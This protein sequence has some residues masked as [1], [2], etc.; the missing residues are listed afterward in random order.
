MKK[1]LL[2][3]LALAVVLCLVFAAA[4]CDPPE[5]PEQP[6]APTEPAEPETPAK[7]S[8]PA[9]P[10]TPGEPEEPATPS[11]TAGMPLK[12]ALDILNGCETFVMESFDPY[13]GE[14]LTYLSYTPAPETSSPGTPDTYMQA[15][16]DGDSITALY[17][18]EST[19]DGWQ[20]TEYSTIGYNG[21]FGK[22]IYRS[23]EALETLL[24]NSLFDLSYWGPNLIVYCL[25][26]MYPEEEGFDI[27]A[28]YAYIEENYTVLKDGWYCEEGGNF[29][30]N[31]TDGAAQ[32]HADND[33]WYKWSVPT[34][35]DAPAEK[36]AAAEAEIAQHTILNAPIISSDMTLEEAV[37]RAAQITTYS[38]SAEVDGKTV[39]YGVVTCPE[40]KTLADIMSGA[41]A[42]KAVLVSY[43]NDKAKDI[44]YFKNDNGDYSVIFHNETGHPIGSYSGDEAAPYGECTLYA[45]SLP[46]LLA[47]TETIPQTQE[48]WDA[49]Y[50]EI[51]ANYILDPAD[52]WYKTSNANAF[53]LAYHL[54]ENAIAFQTSSD[55]VQRWIFDKSDPVELY[56]LT[57]FEMVTSGI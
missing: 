20:L 23:D 40:G 27:E 31:V 17:Y 47:D 30:Y 39:F 21:V 10:E 19:Q 48:E 18:L 5:D 54:E 35:Q 32:I 9:E 11:V 8:T 28:A 12:E 6:A 42:D 56:N 51:D 1:K 3:I 29:F 55:G 24:D 49:L 50:D 57:V 26:D 34:A 44:Q 4:A 53:C 43:E 33:I 15:D 2:L 45:Q 14:L 36:F 22:T 25:A 37:N 16:Y 13:T 7:P 41:V 38:I 52:G 46:L